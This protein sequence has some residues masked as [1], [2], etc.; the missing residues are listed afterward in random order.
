MFTLCSCA[1]RG[2]DTHQ[3]IHY[4][5]NYC[6]HDSEESKIMTKVTTNCCTNN[7]C[8]GP[9]NIHKNDESL[10][11]IVESSFNHQHQHQ[12]VHQELKKCCTDCTPLHTVIDIEPKQCKL[13]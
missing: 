11:E 12:E 9:I 5:S 3:G 4:S 6:S 13:V 7:S 8:K 2:A 1:S 10:G